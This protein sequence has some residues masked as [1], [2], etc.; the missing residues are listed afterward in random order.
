MKRTIIFLF[1]ILAVSAGIFAQNDLDALRHSQYGLI[2]TARALGTGGAFSAVGADISSAWSNPAGLGLFRS[3]T[4][5]ISPV[6]NMVSNQ[7]S[8]LDGQGAGDAINFGVH[9]WGLAFQNQ[10]YYDNGRTRR[11][12]EK[13]LV[14]YTFAFGYNQLENYKNEITASAFNTQSSI[15]QSWADRA[16]GTAPFNLYS[17]SNEYLAFDLILIDTVQGRGG[18]TYFANPGNMQ[19]TLQRLEEGRRNEWFVSLAGNVSDKFYFG[20]TIGIQSLRYEQTFNFNE[21]DINNLYE[22]WDPDPDNGFPLELPTEQIRF[23]E[24]FSTNGVGINGKFGIIV[25]PGDYFRFGLSAQTPTFYSLTDQFNSNLVHVLNL[26]NGGT[27]EQSAA[28][29]SPGQYTYNL[30]TPFRLTAGAM[31]MINKAGFITADVDLNNVS[32]AR[33]SYPGSIND[34]NYYSFDFENGRI[35]NLYRQTINVRLGGEIRADIFRLRA[36]AAMFGTPLTLEAQEYL[37]Y[38][39]LT[40]VQRITGDRRMF[41]LG[42]GVRQPNFYLDVTFINQQQENKFSPYSFSSTDFFSPTVVYKKINNSVVMSVGFN[43]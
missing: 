10:N 27:Q 32:S 30:K 12:I 1:T 16:Q 24:T 4:F 28:P 11:E 33:F 31:Y 8:F 19:Q 25:R 40:T 3:S 5:T 22:F 35:S 26:D 2:G 17:E 20:G 9:N 34:P 23:T 21:E 29:S 6:L 18:R 39:D 42:A 37:D 36:G 15:A 14:S 43:F 41:T 7:T 13:G 38:N